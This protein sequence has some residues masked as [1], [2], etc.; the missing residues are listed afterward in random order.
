V[1]RTVETINLAGEALPGALV[2]AVYE[3]T[4]VKRVVNL[5]GPSETTTYSTMAEVGRREERP[6]IGKPIWNTQVYVLDEGMRLVARGV[7]GELYIGG[8]GVARGYLGKAEQTGERFVPDGYGGER[9]GRLY[10]SGDLAR[11]NVKGELE[12]VGRE[13]QQVKVRG[14][15]IELGE[16]EAVLCEQEGVKEAVVM[17]RE[18]GRGER[19]LVGYGVA[20]EGKEGKEGKEVEWE[21][22]RRHL[23]ERLPGYMVP[24]GMVWMKELPLTPSGK[25]DR[26]ALPEWEAGKEKGEGGKER[27]NEGPGTETEELLAGIWSQVLGRERVGIGENFFELGGHSLLAVQAVNRI[28]ERLGLELPLRILFDASTVAALAKKIEIEEK[29]AG[30]A[31]LLD[32][33]VPVP[34]TD[35]QELIEEVENLSEEQATQLL[36]AETADRTG[37]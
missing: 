26:K 17:V 7:V 29:G 31:G 16:V 3:K 21:E 27:E 4:G 35:L 24:S 9:G 8:A 23:G 13:D 36:A 2:K 15:R 14:Y 37:A 33:I 18:D 10:R 6:A 12:Y 25:V 5:Y 22:L 34:H 30:S 32:A 20:E 1:P 28:N 19:R 11:W